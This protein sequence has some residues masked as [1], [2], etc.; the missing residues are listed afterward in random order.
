MNFYIFGLFLLGSGFSFG[1]YHLNATDNLLGFCDTFNL[2][3]RF[4]AMEET[5]RHVETRLENSERR[6]EQ[7]ETQCQTIDNQ[8]LDLQHKGANEVIFSAALGA[9]NVPV[10]PFKTDT[11]LIYRRVIVNVGGA[12]SNFTGIFAAPVAGVYYFSFFFHAGGENK[13]KLLLYKNGDIIVEAQ[14]NYSWYD[15][16]DNGGNAVFLELQRGDQVYVLLVAGAHVWGS[17]YSTTFSG[18]LVTQT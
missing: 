4:G 2:L 17:D 7:C 1:Q 3:I 10:G 11:I 18:F 13:V 5:L 9:G 6:L 14:E 12:Y 16:A 15:T 8:I